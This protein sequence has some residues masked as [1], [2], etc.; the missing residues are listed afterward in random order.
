MNPVAREVT[1]SGRIPSGLRFRKANDEKESSPIRAFLLFSLLY[2]LYLSLSFS[3]SR[4]Y[5]NP[6]S[7]T[8]PTAGPSYR[9]ASVN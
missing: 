2:S 9:F 6:P 7:I 4:D 1:V 5:S 3:E 8:E